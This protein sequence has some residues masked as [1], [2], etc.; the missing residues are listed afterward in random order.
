EFN[1]DDKRIIVSHARYLEDIRKEASDMVASEKE[2]EHT[3]VKKAIKK[4]QSQVE[5]STLGDIEGFSE[6]ADQLANAGSEAKPEK[7]ASAKKSESSKG[8]DLKK[9]EGIGPKIQ[10]LLNQE[11]ILT[12]DDLAKTDVE[13]IKEILHAAGSRYQMHDPASWPMQAQMAADGKWDDLK[14]WQ[15]NAK[16]GKIE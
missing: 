16:G 15:E 14:V 1:R 5:L 8:D 13:K 11:G 2:K 6:L 12:F 7:K 4:T 10:E 9:I 3:E